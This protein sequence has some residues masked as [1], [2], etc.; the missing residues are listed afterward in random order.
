VAGLCDDVGTGLALLW[1][2]EIKWRRGFWTRNGS[3]PARLARH[4]LRIEKQI[5]ARARDGD[6]REAREGLAYTAS[7]TAQS[8][9]P[10]SR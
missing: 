8:A 5:M 9:V 10:R 1:S 6:D 3:E 2:C 7:T 4:E